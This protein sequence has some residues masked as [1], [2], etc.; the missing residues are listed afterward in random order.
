MGRKDK[1][2]PWSYGPDINM[3]QLEERIVF[4]ASIDPAADQQ[5]DTQDQ[6]NQ[7]NQDGSANP[8][9]NSQAAEPP[10]DPVADSLDSLYPDDLNVILVSNAL[11]DIEAFQQAVGDEAE[12]LVYDANADN[13]GSIND[14]LSDVVNEEGRQIDNLAIL[15]HGEEGGIMMGLDNITF[16]TISDYQPQFEAIGAM[17][18]QDG[19][20]QFYACDVAGNESGQALV[21][22]I[23]YLT[24]ADVF[25]SV[26]DTSNE[27]GDWDLEY[28]S[29]ESPMREFISVEARA[30]ITSTLES[31]PEPLN[32][33]IPD[34]VRFE[35]SV[36]TEIDLAEL[37]ENGE[38]LTYSAFVIPESGANKTDNMDLLVDSD[39]N[40]NGVQLEVSPDGKLMLAYNEYEYGTSVIQVEAS[41]GQEASFTVTVKPV[42]DAAPEALDR[43][44]GLID[45]AEPVGITLEAFDPD[46]NNYVDPDDISFYITDKDG[47]EIL[48]VDGAIIQL[49][50]GQLEVQGGI[51]DLGDQRY[52]IDVEYTV[53]DPGFTEGTENFDYRFTT[54]GNQWL[55]FDDGNSD[56]GVVESTPAYSIDLGDLNKDGYLDIVAGIH[57][58]NDAFYI[59][60]GQG[61][62]TPYY[63]D[64]T[65][66]GTVDVAL[67]D[68][69]ADGFLD[70]VAGVRD[71]NDPNGDFTDLVILNQGF[72]ANNQ[73][74]GFETDPNNY[75]ALP[76]S[77]VRRTDSVAVGDFNNDGL[78]DI[79]TGTGLD[80]NEFQGIGDLDV[81]VY[82]A[83]M[84]S[85]SLEFTPLRI[86]GSAAGYTSALEVGDINADGYLDIY[87]GKKFTGASGDFVF[88][89]TGQE[90]FLTVTGFNRDD[91]NNIRWSAAVA[92]IDMDASLAGDPYYSTFESNR[93]LLHENLNDPNFVNN[94]Q[95]SN[96]IDADI[97]TGNMDN[98]WWGQAN[99]L[100]LSLFQ[101]GTPGYD[102]NNPYNFDESFITMEGQDTNH[103][104]GTGQT[105][106]IDWGDFDRDGIFDVAVANWCGPNQFFLGAIFNGELTFTQEGIND[107][108][109]DAAYSKDVKVGDLN[110]DGLLDLV[111][112]ND[113]CDEGITVHYNLGFGPTSTT[114]M[115]QLRV[116]PPPDGDD[117]DDD[118]PGDDDDD[119]R[120]PEPEITGEVLSSFYAEGIDPRISY[121]GSEFDADFTPRPLIPIPN[122]LFEPPESGVDLL[123]AF[124]LPG[125]GVPPPEWGADLWEVPE[126]TD[127]GA[128]LQPDKGEELRFAEISETQFYTGPDIQEQYVLASVLQTE[129]T[130]QKEQDATLMFCYADAG[131]C[132]IGPAPEAE[133]G[134]SKEATYGEEIASDAT[135]GAGVYDLDKAS[136]EDIDTATP[137]EQ[138]AGVNATAKGDYAAAASEKGKVDI[139]V[140]NVRFMDIIDESDTEE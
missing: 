113:I 89:N 117:D 54:T 91:G 97:L 49:E 41:D 8:A 130:E 47:N 56:Q 34:V 1:K 33:G 7:D 59:N 70:F 12:V 100:L 121:M 82:F 13:V 115:V 81:V 125:I 25:A 32:Q 4:D 39:P 16:S 20:I 40:Q 27:G 83:D 103:Y 78:V 48:A 68:F 119:F 62:F 64:G 44:L 72:D 136:F 31:T 42:Q 126:F 11:E 61:N 36:P 28:S 38:N 132:F 57:G 128:Q 58:D 98:E 65:S 107:L 124:S 77:Q 105:L 66:G 69:N 79:A 95:Y 92:I 137:Q 74:L 5:Q 93:G 84:S 71:T 94:P 111:F 139:D 21:G 99:R 101:E 55:G 87:A 35:D 80:K 96:D 123:N 112:A 110:N 85:G 50:H 138:G 17:M 63:F 26:D 3:E 118:T 104:G 131:A 53:T 29:D 52:T 46:P 90:D 22:A 73:W 18:A 37:F 140:N 102:P 75:I 30:A 114:A 45:P 129:Q 9:S 86:A 108:S 23:S 88:L 106:G 133:F 10:D 19:Q 135:Y 24:N 60:D 67:G 43:D 109:Y 51:N 14:M 120:I 6:Q 2:D 127:A 116:E 134:A 76:D 122:Y 15:G